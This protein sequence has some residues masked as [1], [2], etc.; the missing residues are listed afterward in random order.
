MKNTFVISLVTLF[1]GCA[2][3]SEIPRT[4]IPLQVQYFR[5]DSTSLAVPDSFQAH[6]IDTCKAMPHIAKK[7][8]PV[9]Q[10]IAIR[11][12]VEGDIVVRIFVRTNGKV[13]R[14][15]IVYASSE[16]FNKDAIDAVMAWSFSPYKENCVAKEFIADVPMAFRFQ[17]GHPEVFTPQN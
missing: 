5:I 1:L 6:N 9:Y 7:V 11:A 8:E 13:Q 17:H 12:R 3:A 2:S 10:P 15:R 16:L 4:A 14:C